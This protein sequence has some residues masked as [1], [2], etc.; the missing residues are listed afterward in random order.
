MSS[1]PEPP[2]DRNASNVSLR[3]VLGTPL[4]RSIRSRQQAQTA[5]EII[6]EFVKTISLPASPASLVLPDQDGRNWKQGVDFRAVYRRWIWFA[7]TH[8]SA[9]P[10][11]PY[12]LPNTQTAFGKALRQVVGVSSKFGSTSIKRGERSEEDL[13]KAIT[14]VFGI[15]LKPSSQISF[16]GM[17]EPWYP[18]PWLDDLTS[19]GFPM[20]TP[21]PKAQIMFCVRRDLT[22][23]EAK[24]KAD[25]AMSDRRKHRMI[26]H[27]RYASRQRLELLAFAAMNPQA[28]VNAGAPEGQV[29]KL[30]CWPDLIKNEE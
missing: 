10:L 20:P 2:G 21:D 14:R 5:K 28:V 29:W 7:Q 13:P 26:L 17:F 25:P 12:S 6:A 19:M 1:M 8:H 22:K 16:E 24:I 27:A 30:S 18:Q 9:S 4:D 15:T 23:F 3:D 11:W